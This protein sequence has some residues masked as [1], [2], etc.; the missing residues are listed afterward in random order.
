[1]FVEEIIY[2][3]VVKL[4]FKFVD[5]KCVIFLYNICILWNKKVWKRKENVS[6][7]GNIFLMYYII[8]GN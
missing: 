4:D 8:C 5:D 7:F 2:I 1:M 3:V 6:Y